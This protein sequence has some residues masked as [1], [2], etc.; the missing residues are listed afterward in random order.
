VEI[1]LA[2][3]TVDAGSGQPVPLRRVAEQALEAERL[4]YSSAWVMDHLF[5]DRDGARGGAHDPFVQLGHLAAV[6]TRITLGVLVAGAPFRHPAQLAREAAAVA[7]AAPGR[8]V[9]G[10]GAGWHEPEFAAFDL[11]FERKVSRLAEYVPIVK[12]LL[13]GERLNASGDFYALRQASILTTAPP[14]PVWVAAFKPRMIEL[15]SEFADGWNAAWLEPDASRFMELKS[16]VDEAQSRVGRRGRLLISAGVQVGSAGD[17][18]EAIATYEKA[19]AD[20]VVF[21]FGERP[22][23]S[24]EPA[25]MKKPFS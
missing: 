20:H 12:R 2:L 11:P 19:G 23:L 7:D 10:L 5:L 14:P 8:F 9:L 21:N 4:G 6:T 16:M 1:G 24:Y 25:L 22:F 18:Q 15:T 17:P 13:A 3:G